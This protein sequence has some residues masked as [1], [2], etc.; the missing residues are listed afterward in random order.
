MARYR[1][2][3]DLMWE[4]HARVQWCVGRRW[5][6]VHCTLRNL[7]WILIG[8]PKSDSIFRLIFEHCTTF[9]YLKRRTLCWHHEGLLLGTLLLWWSRGFKEGEKMAFTFSWIEIHRLVQIG[10]K[11]THQIGE[12]R[13]GGHTGNFI[14]LVCS[15]S[16]F[17]KSLKSEWFRYISYLL[18]Y[19]WI[20]LVNTLCYVVNDCTMYIFEIQLLFFCTL[21][22]F[23]FYGEIID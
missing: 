14:R 2:N 7:F 10:E 21:Y 16:V 1:V 13:C 9:D 23:E 8:K 22:T 11:K 6:G 3:V 20:Q 19:K 15:F 18:V 17:W 4:V 12:V 5:A